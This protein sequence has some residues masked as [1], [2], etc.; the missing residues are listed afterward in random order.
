MLHEEAVVTRNVSGVLDAA[1]TAKE[2]AR[3]LLRVHGARGVD[4]R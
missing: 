4:Q 2:A 3:A 1:H